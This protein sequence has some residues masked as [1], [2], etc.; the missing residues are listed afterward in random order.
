MNRDGQEGEGVLVQKKK[1]KSRTQLT[2]MGK[3]PANEDGESS[4]DVGDRGLGEGLDDRGQ[5]LMCE[6]K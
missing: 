2:N 1:K 6:V 5:R 4:G 3:I